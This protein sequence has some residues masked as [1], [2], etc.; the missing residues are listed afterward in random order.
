MK[1]PLLLVLLFIALSCAKQTQPTGGP[2]DE[3]PPVLID[4][5]P[6]MGS[7]S[8]KDSKIELSFSEAVIVDKPKE[9][10]LISPSVKGFET[11]YRKNKVFLTFSDP[12]AD[13]T[14]YNLNFRESIKDITEKNPAQNLTLAF[15]T[16]AY[17]DSLSVSGNTFDLLTS[18]EI[19]DV[20]VAVAFATDTFN[21]FKHKAQFFTKASKEGFY[22]IENLKPAKYFIYA[23]QDKNKNLL[24]DSKNEK[25]GF[26]GQSINLKE[27]STHLMIPIIALDSRPI[28]LVSAKPLQNYFIL[29]TNKGIKTYEVT[30]VRGGEEVFSRGSDE[31]SIKIF[32]TDTDSDSTLTRIILS[33]SLS[34]TIDTTLYIKFNP[35]KEKTTLDKFTIKTNQAKVLEKT[36]EMTTSISFSKPI[37][38]I[39]MDSI[40]FQ[41]DSANSLTLNESNVKLDSQT[42][43]LHITINLPKQKE[44][45]DPK[46]E[47]DPSKRK[48][49]SINELRLGKGALLS[50]DNDSSVY[51]IIRPTYYKEEDLAITLVDVKTTSR[52]YFIELLNQQNQIIAKSINNPKPTFKD[53]VPGEYLLR[54]IIDENNNGVWDPGNYFTNR[55]PE[56]I[57]YYYDDKNN[58][59]FTLKANWEYGPLLITSEYSVDK[60]RNESNKKVKK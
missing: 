56:K 48:I 8:F 60:K 19:N 51:T 40:Y 26:I 7:V 36:G 28:K 11:T 17:L 50:I 35:I 34:N 47:A 12:L 38:R 10:I 42:L 52:H 37:K 44:S 53:I 41:L 6:K 31:A 20:T 18:K 3:Q 24:V 21:I 43:Q 32:N 58:Q 4:S 16:G 59:K 39:L 55:E 2:K 33:D 46:K 29:K 23:F 15:S 14:T 1:Y 54:L 49:I 45:N 27:D 30:F 57:F 13:S 9:Q 5:N 25:Y 22:N